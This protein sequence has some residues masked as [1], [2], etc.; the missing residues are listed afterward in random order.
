MHQLT[1][2]ISADEPELEKHGIDLSSW[3]PDPSGRVTVTLV[4]YSRGAAEYLLRRYGNDRI[5][6]SQR[7]K[8][9]ARRFIDRA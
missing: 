6:V 8:P 5:S 7:S 4:H 3:G 9:L 1:M 2:R